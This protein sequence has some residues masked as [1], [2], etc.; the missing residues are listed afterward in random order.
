MKTRGEVS[1]MVLGNAR[2]SRR[3]L[4]SIVTTRN[5]LFHFFL[6]ATWSFQ[7]PDRI[8]AT[9]KKEVQ[10]VTSAARFSFFF[11]LCVLVYI[12]TSLSTSKYRY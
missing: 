11:S 10:L 9:G 12:H 5:A 3:R 8:T 7:L 1:E 6:R 2:G 4:E